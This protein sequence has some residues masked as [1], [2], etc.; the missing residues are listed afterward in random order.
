MWLLPIFVGRRQGDIDWAGKRILIDSKKTRKHKPFRTIPLFPELE[1]PLSEAYDQAG[2]GAV[3]CI[4]RYRSQDVN[5]RTGLE[6]IIAKAKVETWPRLWQNLR[7]S[8]ETELANEYP[9]Q[10]VTDGLGNSPR[11][12]AQHYLQTTDEHFAKATAQGGTGGGDKGGQK[13][14]TKPT[15]GKSD[16]R[17]ESQETPTNEGEKAKPI[18]F[19]DD[20]ENDQIRL[21]GFEPPTYGLGNRCSIP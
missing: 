15:E 14:G 20:S 7:A 13:V 5:L 10:V 17:N 18:V 9:I 2:E 19:A 16:K 21:R 4:E 6:R 8:R 11:V 12:A 3:Y 1:Q